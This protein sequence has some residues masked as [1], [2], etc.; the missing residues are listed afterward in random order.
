MQQT[1]KLIKVFDVQTFDSGFKKRE[2]VIDTG[3]EYAQQLKFELLKDNVDKVK[4]SDNGRQV[5]LQFDIRGR[6]WDGKYFVNLVAWKV[7]FNSAGVNGSGEP[8][9]DEQSAFSAD[10]SEL[11]DDNDDLPF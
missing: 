6:E 10:L 9:P 2:V 11:S 3:G 7:D 4:E 5:T 1:G 8:R